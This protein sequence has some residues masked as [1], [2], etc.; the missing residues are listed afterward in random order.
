MPVFLSHSKYNAE[1]TV[2]IG[3]FLTDNGIKCYIDVLDSSLK[4][5]DDITALILNRITTCSHMMAVISD[6]TKTSWWVPFEIGVASRDD[7]RITSYRLTAIELP[8]YL[9]KWPIIKSYQDLI[10]FIENYKK[11]NLVPMS[12]SIRAKAAY[13]QDTIRSSDQFHR[14]LKR[15]LGQP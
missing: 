10:K 11:D 6:F 3:K 14:E 8:E 4:T 12:E 9:T 2:K 15:A 7:K 1:D 13:T 5:T